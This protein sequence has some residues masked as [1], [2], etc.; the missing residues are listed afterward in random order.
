VTLPSQDIRWAEFAPD[1]S[2]YSAQ[3]SDSILNVEPRIDGYGP[4]A[5]LATFGTALPGRCVGAFNFRRDDGSSDI[6]AGTLT[7]LYKFNTAT[8]SWDD[9]TRLVGGDYT[10]SVGQY[11][12]FAQYRSRLIATNG[13]DAVQYMDV[14]AGGTNFAALPN[15][16]IGKYAAVVG[17]FLM[18]ADLDTDITAVAWSGINNS[19]YWTYG[20][21]GSDVQS[22]PDGGRIQGIVPYGQGAVIFQ[23]DK[24]RLMERVSGNI[25]FAVRILHESIGC[26]APL[27]I[28]SIGN[29]FFWYDQGG[30]YRG[31]NAQPIGAERVNRYAAET[32]SATYAKNMRGISDPTKQLVWWLIDTSSTDTEM[33][34][35]DYQLNKWTRAVQDVDFIFPAITPGYTIDAIDDL[36]PTMDDIAFPFDSP[37]WNGNGIL[38]MA[39]FTQ[40]GEF[41][42]FQGFN[43]AATLE[44][45]DFE[46]A[47]G[48]YGYLQSARVISDARYNE[49]TV[50][51]GYRPFHGETMTFATAVQPS[52]STGR[53]FLRKRGKTNRI[54]VNFTEDA[55]WNY[56]NGV[57]VYARQA[58]AR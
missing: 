53:A 43:L 22:F 41:G 36:F 50:Q 13:V 44:T 8:A 4:L 42:Y 24:I 32:A 37:F 14:D 17:D 28:V 23:R 29:D 15:A 31:I 39:G 27:S 16:P 52:S 19:E 57:T 26:F 51:V 20:F 34:G 18:I 9:V 49:C 40:A 2:P 6:F 45:N 55:T 7:K 33:L 21:R 1:A 48:N 3:F 38:T 5:K 35:Y 30:Y 56:A 46:I 54:R 12:S 11:W 58:G 10:M 25:I 47:A